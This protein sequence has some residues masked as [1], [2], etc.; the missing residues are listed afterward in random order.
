MGEEDTENGLNHQVLTG[1]LG[2]HLIL[3]GK[4]NVR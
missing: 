3:E 1:I 2:Q 4:V